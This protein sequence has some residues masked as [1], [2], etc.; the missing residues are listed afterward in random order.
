MANQNK[1]YI[2]KNMVMLLTEA[3][4]RRC[5]IRKVLLNISQNS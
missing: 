3:V 4:E 2:N 1:E 5:S